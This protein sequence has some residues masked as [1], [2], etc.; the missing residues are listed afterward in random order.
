MPNHALGHK[1]I[2][3]RGTLM[4]ASDLWHARNTPAS[5]TASS[6]LII[7][8]HQWCKPISRKR[9]I[10]APH[11]S[12]YHSHH[13][14]TRHDAHGTRLGQAG[15]QLIGH[16]F[17]SGQKRGQRPFLSRVTLPRAGDNHVVI[18]V[19][20]SIQVP[21]WRPMSAS[22][23]ESHLLD[24]ERVLIGSSYEM[25]LL[26]WIVLSCPCDSPIIIIRARI[27]I[28][29]TTISTNLLN[30]VNLVTQST[31]ALHIPPLGRIGLQFSCDNLVVIVSVVGIQVPHVVFLL[32]SKSAA[33]LHI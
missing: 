7:V 3:M 2:S 8:V 18:S 5:A 23:I 26:T 33:H 25:P 11:Q 12:N 6:C 29:K 21:C 22:T 17:V 32:D 13:G 24:P 16:H 9:P 19:C 30:R 10:A 1:T 14:S 31:N 28:K 4:L 20:V 27:G 15:N